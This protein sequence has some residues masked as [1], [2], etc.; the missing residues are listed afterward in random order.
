[1]VFI[2][3]YYSLNQENLLQMTNLQ[4][5]ALTIPYGVMNSTSHRWVYI[6]SI[7]HLKMNPVDV[8]QST[9]SLCTYS[10]GKIFSCN[11][12][13]TLLSSKTAT[14]IAICNER[15]HNQDKFPSSTIKQ[16]LIYGGCL[17][18]LARSSAAQSTSAASNIKESW[19]EP[20]A[21]KYLSHQNYFK[22][23]TSQH[24][25]QERKPGFLVAST[26][27]ATVTLLSHSY[28]TCGASLY[29]NTFPTTY[30]WDEQHHN[31]LSC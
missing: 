29:L 8:T 12:W 14:V 17:A 31:P 19:G 11:F 9:L 23:T 27:D 20:Q 6:A 1:M 7:T 21:R 24:K 15:Y 25:N 22:T 30:L 4:N 28:F 10:T 18:V 2:R 16:L 26:T 3:W 13:K 5:T